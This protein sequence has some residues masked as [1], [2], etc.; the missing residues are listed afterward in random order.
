[1]TTKIAQLRIE[2]EHGVSDPWRDLTSLTDARIALGR[3]GASMPTEEVLRLSYAHAKARDAVH[4]GLDIPALTTSLEQ[5]QLQTIKVRSA[6]TDRMTYLRRP[7]YGRKVSPHDIERLIAE[8]CAGVTISIVIA[9]GLSAT[10]VQANTV[11]FLSALLPLLRNTGANIAPAVIVHNGRVA[12]GDEIG[13]R[14]GADIVLVLIGERPGLSAADSLGLYITYAP[15]IGRSDAERNCISNIRTGG[16]AP[17]LAAKKA[18]WLIS[19]ALS[20]KLTGVELKDDDTIVTLAPCLSDEG[21][22]VCK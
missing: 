4:A 2:T 14:L 16:L 11:P 5:L 6:A 19:E 7:D 13:H 21:S 8:P 10:A 12:I 3:V 18:F 20:R 17:S 9:D 22:S 15:R 1:M